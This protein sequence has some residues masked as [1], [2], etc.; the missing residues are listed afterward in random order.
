MVA[1]RGKPAASD[2]IVHRPRP[3][4]GRAAPAAGSAW[5]TSTPVTHSAPAPPAVFCDAVHAHTRALMASGEAAAAVRALPAPPTASAVGASPG[6]SSALTSAP[7]VVP[8]DAGA[9]PLG[10]LPPCQPVAGDLRAA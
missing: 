8:V 5:V 4:R 6:V 1:E 10:R 3:R 9:P 7:L 2:D